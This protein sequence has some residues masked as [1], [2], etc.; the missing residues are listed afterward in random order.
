MD[1]R[2]ADEQWKTWS[3]RLERVIE[4]DRYPLSPRIRG[5]ARSAPF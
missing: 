5:D 1:L 2:S 4:N 3:P